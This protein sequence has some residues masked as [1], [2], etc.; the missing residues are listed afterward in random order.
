MYKCGN[1]GEASHKKTSFVGRTPFW[2]KRR[3]EKLREDKNTNNWI[4]LRGGFFFCFFWKSDGAYLRYFETCRFSSLGLFFR[5]PSSIMRNFVYKSGR[6][7]SAQGRETCP[8][9]PNSRRQ[10]ERQ[11]RRSR[12]QG[13]L[14]RKKK[15][16]RYRGGK[17]MSCTPNKATR[18]KQWNAKRS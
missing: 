15:R 6:I 9:L 10:S 8:W 11:G 14:I 3:T 2:E 5:V 17:K 16:W 12:L 7:P 18:W 4:F 13:D 1:G